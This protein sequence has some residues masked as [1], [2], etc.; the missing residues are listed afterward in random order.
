MVLFHG[1]AR[2]SD[3]METLAK[4]LH[5]EGYEVINIDYDSTE[6]PL[7]ELAVRTSKKM[8]SLLVED[9]PVN[10]VG[11]SM[12][13]ILSRAIINLERPQNLNR[14]VHL[15]TPNNGSEVADFFKDN[16]LFEYIYGP[17]GQQLT[18]EQAAEMEKVFGKVDYE[19]GVIAGNS[20]IDP[21][22]SWIIP[23]ENDGKVSLK[24]TQIEG[25]VD[26]TV[27]SATH[28]FFPRNKEVQ[29]HTVDFLKHGKFSK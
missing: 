2:G 10:I 11:Y 3:S 29:Q 25:M 8:N 17:A 27:V 7:E 23:G 14:V 13:G 12:G 16:V 18:T 28:T 6:Y 5:K 9:K 19:L 21:I 26:H 15:A 20:T 24:S 22:S 1:I 4:R